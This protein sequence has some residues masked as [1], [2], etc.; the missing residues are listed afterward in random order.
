MQRLKLS[1]SLSL[2]AAST[3]TGDTNHVFPSPSDDRWHYPFNSTPGTRPRGSTFG[4]IGDRSPQGLQRFNERDGVIIVAWNTTALVPPGQGAASYPVKSVRVSLT[5]EALADWPVDLTVDEW[6][7]YDVNADGAINADGIARG[8][9]GD[10][11][12]ESDDD[13]AGRPF[14]L[15]GAGFAPDV[16]FFDELTWV[17]TTFFVG[18]NQQPFPVARNPFP[19]VFQDV[20]LAKLHCEDNVAGLHNEALG[21]ASF[22]P[23]PWAVG[24]PIGYTPGSQPSPFEVRFDVDLSQSCGA[25]R[26]YFA[27]QLDKGRIIVIVTSLV[28]TF[29]MAP[30]GFPSFYLNT[31]TPGENPFPARLEITLGEALEGDVDGDGDVDLDD[32]QLLTSVLLD[33]P[34]FSQEIRER[35]DLNGDGS[36]NGADIAPFVQALLGVGC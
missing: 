21:V 4:S 16:P 20:T 35:S 27:D 22:T 32:A 30:S 34:A 8:Q 6:F 9:P 24:L 25:V 7:T 18:W 33:P 23:T 11:D 5:H 29:E 2:L 10:T 26:G 17:E 36:A 19:F 1:L 15:F 31:G 14:E 13:D 12:G 3:A 28:E